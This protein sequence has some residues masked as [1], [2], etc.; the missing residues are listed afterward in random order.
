MNSAPT[1]VKTIRTGNR[2]SIS[3]HG[4]FD[5][6]SHQAFR[7]AYEQVLATDNV[8]VDLAHTEY[9]DSSALGMLLVLKDTVGGKPIQIVGCRPAVKRIL[10]IANFDRIFTIN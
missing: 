7:Q 5:F 6:G 9:L 2:F 3:I 10:E 8:F 4:R 1:Q